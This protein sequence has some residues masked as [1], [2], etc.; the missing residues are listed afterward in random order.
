MYSDL[1]KSLKFGS[2]TKLLQKLYKF[3]TLTL[4]YSQFIVMGPDSLMLM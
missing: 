1:N 3:E 4:Q 2:L